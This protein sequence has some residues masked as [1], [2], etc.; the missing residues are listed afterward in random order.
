MKAE[1]LRRWQRGKG[2]GLD[3]KARSGSENR[4]LDE[5]AHVSARLMRGARRKKSA[6]EAVVDEQSVVVEQAALGFIY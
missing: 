6:Q 2:N 3:S 5:S 1:L 4:A